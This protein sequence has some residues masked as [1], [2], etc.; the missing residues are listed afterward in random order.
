[1][2]SCACILVARGDGLVKSLGFAFSKGDVRWTLVTG[3]QLVPT[4]VERGREQYANSYEGRELINWFYR[5]LT[6]IVQ[7]SDCDA[8]T[9]RLA[10]KIRN[11]QQ[12]YNLI[13]PCAL[14]AQVCA[15]RK[16][17]CTTLG[18]QT[19]T[20]KALGFPKGADLYQ[21]CSGLIGSYP[22]NWDKKQI[23]SALTAILGLR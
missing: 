1:M 11:Q 21:H 20:A 7:R 15:D 22:P 6:E 23:D 16:V 5:T 8:V 13:F 14:A 4:F 17:V 18:S 19:I 2:L 3:S 9:V 10:W 12:A